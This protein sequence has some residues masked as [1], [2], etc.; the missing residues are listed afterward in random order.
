[1][2]FAARQSFAIDAGCETGNKAFEVRMDAEGASDALGR[3]Y[4]KSPWRLVP[5]NPPTEMISGIA[6]LLSVR[7]LLGTVRTS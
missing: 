5:T 7:H 2:L 1:V 6:H 3:R 4:R